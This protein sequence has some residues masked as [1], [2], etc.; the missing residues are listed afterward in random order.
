MSGLPENLTTLPDAEVAETPQGEYPVPDDRAPLPNGPTENGEDQEPDAGLT[1]SIPGLSW[2]S[3]TGA[4]L[5]LVV[6]LTALARDAAA[7]LIATFGIEWLSTALAGLETAALVGLVLLICSVIYR[8]V[9]S[10]LHLKSVLELR[11][12]YRAASGRSATREDRETLKKGVE[13]YI[14]ELDERH[15][16]RYGKEIHEL[17]KRARE[18]AT[19]QELA[20]DT[21]EFLLRQMDREARQ[22]IA[23]EAAGAG[24]A[25]AISPR[26]L[27]DVAIVLWRNVRMV[28]K[29]ARI[30]AGRTGRY[31]TWLI[32]RRAIASAA[33][34]QAGENISDQ[35]PAG[36]S[37]KA[38]G[39]LGQCIG[40]ALMTYRVGAQ[41]QKQCRPP[42]F[43]PTDEPLKN[44]A[45]SIIRTVWR[46]ATGKEPEGESD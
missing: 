35:L 17:R 28:G 18:V 42:P 12:A 26:G 6:V 43:S 1:G 30:Y 25:T 31:G 8:E 9:V 13:N 7:P 21:E 16:G 37:F 29:I 33:V 38:I 11:D 15:P 45:P 32:A 23:R 39:A 40:N 4:C 34:A 41:A 36:I 3:I 20:E 14:A 27:I 5:L 46:S 10:Y 44:V 2:K 24:I 19:P 22:V